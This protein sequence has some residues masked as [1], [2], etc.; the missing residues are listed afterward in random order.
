MVNGK[1]KNYRWV[2]D[3]GYMVWTEHPKEATLSRLGREPQLIDLPHT[4]KASEM[5]QI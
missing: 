1:E 5:R 2:W 3:R 4:L